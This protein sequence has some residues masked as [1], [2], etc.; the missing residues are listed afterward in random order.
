MA[1]ALTNYNSK[2]ARDSNSRGKCFLAAFARPIAQALDI[3]MSDRG[4]DAQRFHDGHDAHDGRDAQRFHDGRGAL[5][6]MTVI[7]P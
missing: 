3:Y 4:H 6:Y 2:G 5:A 7:H 1:V